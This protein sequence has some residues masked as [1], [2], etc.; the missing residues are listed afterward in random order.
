MTKTVLYSNV[1]D[2][3]HCFL[4]FFFT[5]KTIYQEN[6]EHS[7]VL[8]ELLFDMVGSNCVSKPLYPHTAACVKP[9]MCPQLT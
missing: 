3:F 8:I 7:I 6:N 2:I 1:M 4:I 5:D 9:V